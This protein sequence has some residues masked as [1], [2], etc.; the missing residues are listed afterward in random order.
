[1]NQQ[2]PRSWRVSPRAPM[3]RALTPPVGHKWYKIANKSAAVAEVFVYDEIGY[4]GITAAD[5][6]RDLQAI[7][8][9]RIN[10]R[11]N[12][13]GGEVFDGIACYEALRR[14]PATVTSYIDGLAA[15]IASVIAMAG[16]RRV[17]ARNGTVMVHDAS[18]LA[19]GPAADMRELADLLDKMSDNIADVYTQRAGGTVKKWRE[20]MLAETW[21]VGAEAVAAGLATELAT[22]QDADEWEQATAH[23]DRGVAAD[24]A[25]ATAH[26]TTPAGDDDLLAKLR[27]TR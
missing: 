9:P 8:A 4:F 5:F 13:P 20:A 11:L 7:T 6:A 14:H 26:L 18:G 24:W 22:D 3:A 16:D 25:R 12:S 15:S 17:I 21:Y 10:L 27:E 23:L 2:W 19:I 1:M